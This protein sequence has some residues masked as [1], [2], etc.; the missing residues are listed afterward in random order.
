MWTAVQAHAP[1]RNS[2][3]PLSNCKECDMVIFDNSICDS[4]GKIKPNEEKMGRIFQ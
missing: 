3:V 1:A 4:L 2:I